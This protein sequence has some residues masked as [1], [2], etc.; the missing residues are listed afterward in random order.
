MDN[1]QYC[2][3]SQTSTT[4]K[5]DKSIKSI[6]L[7]ECTGSETA[8]YIDESKIPSFNKP[9]KSPIKL[10]WMNIHKDV[11]LFIDDS[12]IRKW[13]RDACNYHK[14]P[15]ILLALI[16][17]N[18]NNP[19]APGWRKSAQFA[20]RTITT[21]ANIVDKVIFIVPD[22]VSK[23]SSGIANV[24]DKALIDG[25]QNSLKKYCRPPIPSSIVKNIIGLSTDTRISGDDWRNDLYYAAA[26]LRYL[27][28]RELGN[29]FNGAMTTEQLKKVIK[30]YN[31]SGPEAEKYAN[32]ALANLNLAITGKG[33][34]YFYEK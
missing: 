27:I 29:C 20:E 12:E 21:A 4:P 19:N 23:G 32:N 8:T 10:Y 30:A 6:I 1:L 31:G 2:D 11:G 9:F 28:D 25:V 5:T 3:A 17:Q 13:V 7:C 16:L 33:T 15:H 18:E 22:K 24:S 26:H 34:L 14:I